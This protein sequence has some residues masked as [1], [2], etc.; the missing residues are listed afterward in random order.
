MN[1]S[2]GDLSLGVWFDVFPWAMGAAVFAYF[3]LSGSNLPSQVK[4]NLPKLFHSRAVN[5]VIAVFFVLMA[6]SKF[7]RW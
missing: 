5:A 6:L 4:Q 2:T 1:Q 3:A 7:L